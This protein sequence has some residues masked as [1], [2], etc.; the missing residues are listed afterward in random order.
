MSKQ[1][2]HRPHPKKTA[3]PRKHEG[4]GG[5]RHGYQSSNEIEDMEI[6][7]DDP[8]KRPSDDGKHDAKSIDDNG[9]R[10]RK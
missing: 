1:S 4:Q 3:G 8:G 10:E 9:Y 2:T 5:S 7:D 6:F